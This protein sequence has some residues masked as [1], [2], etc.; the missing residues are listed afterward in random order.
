[1]FTSMK[2]F[3]KYIKENPVQAL[4]E[5]C[6]VVAIFVV[7]FALMFMAGVFQS[8]SVHHETLSSGKATIVTVDTT[9]IYHGGNIKFPKKQ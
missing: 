2:D 9:Y 7:W 4:K 8:C 6:M 1:M 5:F 3:V